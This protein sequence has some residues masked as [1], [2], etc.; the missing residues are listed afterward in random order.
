MAENKTDS[1][2]AKPENPRIAEARRRAAELSRATGGTGR[3]RAS[4]GQFFQEVWTE[5]KKTTW[6]DRDT[7]AK[8]VYVVMAFI[9]TTGVWIFV[10]SYVLGQVMAPLFRTK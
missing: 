8:S 9:V 7:L 10:I 3:N 4:A 5:L 1:K 2:I 6:P